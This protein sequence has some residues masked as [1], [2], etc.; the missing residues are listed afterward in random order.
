MNHI[1]QCENLVKEVY[2]HFDASHDFQ[3]IERVRK[4]AF[5]IADT[6]TS[7]NREIIEL[8]VLLHDVSDP[9]YS[10]EEK[11]EEERIIK[12]LNLTEE[13]EAQVKDVIK[14]ISFNGG[15]EVKAVTIEAK[16]VRDADRLDAIGAVGIARTFAYG[17][18][19]GRLLY[20]PSETPREN[21]S[22]EEYRS[23]KTASVTH[24]YEKL[25]K[26]SDGMQTKKGKELAIERH[27]FMEL[28]LENLRR[29]TGEQL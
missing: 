27:A 19:K 7:A 11:R 9:K 1:E 8:A 6:E 3:H 2:R 24:F 26:L 5:D 16:I 25:L 28:F 18:A 17:G 23:K 20:D 13:K 29:E 10:T 4:N 14:A 12:H 15:H 22:I 21:M